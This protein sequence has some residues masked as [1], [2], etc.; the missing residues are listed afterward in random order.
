MNDAA[1][2]AIT[3]RRVTR[4]MSAE[5][6]APE[7]FELVI[8]AARHAPN[9]G[10]RRLQPVVPVTDPRLLRL[11]RLIAPG[12][13]PR[14]QAAAVICID[15]ARALDYGFR[16]DAPGLYVD[17]GTTAATL[18]LAA[19]AVGLA[20][21]PVTSF[22]RAAAGRL[23]GLAPGVTA[24]MI[25]CLGHAAVDQPLAMGAWARQPR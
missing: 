14:P 18:L 13:V 25:V 7:A 15:V 22:S 16:P 21:C 3:S 4:N 9:A 1:Y 17:V 19:H 12:M 8:G 6:V 24:Q 10:N 11:L 20:S 23:L 2:A 5:P